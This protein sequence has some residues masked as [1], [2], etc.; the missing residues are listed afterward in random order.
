MN[1]LWVVPETHQQ[2]KLDIVARIQANGGSDRLPGAVPMLCQPGD[3][4]IMNRQVLHGPFANTSTVMR[5]TYQF[6]F[7]SR[8]V[9]NQASPCLTVMW[10]IKPDGPRV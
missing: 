10:G 3:V 9:R 6:G 5:A 2:Y 4:V 1:A 7:H 8:E